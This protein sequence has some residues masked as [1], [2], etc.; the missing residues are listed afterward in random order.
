MT[1]FEL[2]QYTLLFITAVI[3]GTGFV[4]QKLGM[5]HVEPFTFTF[6]RTLIGGLFLL[7][8]MALMDA[9]KCRRGVTIHRSNRRM[10]FWGSVCCGLCLITAESFQ[11][12]G[13]ALS[14]VT[15]S[16]FIT[17]L[18][19]VFVPI[20][21]IALGR[22]PSF[23]IAVC[24]A[25]SVAGLYL[26]C[27]KDELRFTAGDLLL[28]IG[29]AIFAVHILVI[30][31]FVAR[32]D[33]VALSCGQ[34]FVAS[35]L[36]LIMMPATGGDTWENFCAAAPAFIYCGLMS[37]G[38]A[39]TLQVVGQRGVNS[40]IATLILSLESV[41]GTFFGIVLL[42]ESPSLRQLLGCALMFCA[43]ILSQIPLKTLLS[44][45]ARKQRAAE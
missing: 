18:Y 25:L 19:V 33:G 12:F 27:I 39:Y 29:A 31:Y 30:A 16:S 37:N 23:K 15:K 28:L 11:Q 32:V 13:V 20:F 14:D 44:P 2:R 17:A 45:L 4:G 43:V 7:P 24:V 40:T 9:A 42:G 6:A 10:L 1:K 22:W 8:V 34:F 38:V 35:F 3:W 36:G 21:G 41:T 5:D 26:L